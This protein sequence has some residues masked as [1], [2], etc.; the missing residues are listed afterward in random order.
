MGMATLWRSHEFFVRRV[1]KGGVQLGV[2]IL[3]YPKA[4]G[5]EPKGMPPKWSL[6]V[7]GGK[8]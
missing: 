5:V 6:H 1:L 4:S 3:E 8:I 7:Y 2:Y